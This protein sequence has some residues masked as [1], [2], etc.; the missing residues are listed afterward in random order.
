[1]R[2]PAPR[3]RRAVAATLAAGLLVA[4]AA[5]WQTA[6]RPPAFAASGAPP[7]QESTPSATEEPAAVPT[8]K[9]IEKLI[10]DDQARAAL[11]KV[12]VVLAAARERGDAAEWTRALI[13]AAQLEVALGEF[14]TAVERLRGTPWPE[15]AIHR[16]PLQL[17]YGHSLA[18]YLQAYRW[19]IAQRERVAS[20]EGEPAGDL[21]AWTVEQI[22]AGAHGAF[23]AAWQGREAWGGEPVSSLERY[24]APGNYPKGIRGTLR[25]AV[26]YLWAEL[27]VDSSFWSP[28]QNDA[29][30]RLDLE[31]LIAGEGLG[32]EALAD[33]A[34]HP[35]AKLAAV[36]GDLERWHAGAGR[37]EASF[38]AL[39]VRL[40]RLHGH[41]GEAEDRA[42]IRAALERGLDSLGRERPW[43]SMGMATLASMVD[44]SAE[45]DARARALEIAREG[46]AA[47][48]ESP[49]GQLCRHLAA[50]I[51]APSCSV[52]SMAADGAGRRSIQVTHK[53]LP[54]LWFRA[55]RLDLQR[56]IEGSA[57]GGRMLPD[58]R[59]V[60]GILRGTPAA[61]W[62]VDLPATPDHRPHQ[63]YVTPPFERPGLWVVVASAAEG[64]RRDGNHLQ[65]VNLVITD[66]VLVSRPLADGIETTVRAGAG[67]EALAG[68]EVALYRFD[69][70]KSHS[71]V[72]A[73]TTSAAGVVT[74]R[75]PDPGGEE[76]PVYFP[77]AR[78]GEDVAAD[79]S[80]LRPEGP[81]PEAAPVET[82]LIYTDRSVYRPGQEL[83]W[84][85]VAFGG[86]WEAGRYEVL[87]GR[88]LTVEL[89][90]VNDQLVAS[91]EVSTNDYG[92]ASGRF[93]VPAGRPLGG[94]R[95]LTSLD[96]SAYVQVEEYKRPTFE[97]TVAEPPE[98]LRLNREA[99]LAGEARYY[100][101]LPVAEGRVRWTVHR[102]PVFPWWWWWW[103]RPGG[104][105]RMVAAGEAELGA[106]GGFEVAFTPEADE[107]DAGTGVSYRFRLEAAVTDPGG[108]TR[109]A[110]RA[111]RLGFVAVEA[112]IEAERGFWDAGQA[113]ELP[114]VRT[115]LD[116]TP[117]AGAASWTLLAI[118]VPDE[119]PLPADLP[120][121]ELPRTAAPDA[122]EDAFRTPGDSLRPRWQPDYQPERALA[123]WPDGER[124]AAG[125]A[126]HGE[127]GRAVLELPALAA[128]AYRLRYRTE[129]GAGSTFETQHELIVAAEGSTPLPL[130]LVLLAERPS[131]EAGGTA[132]LFVHS[133][134]PGQEM[135]LELFRGGR[136]VERRTIEG[137]Q[138]GHLVEIPV[139]DDD[140]GGFGV[141]LTALAD[142][143]LMSLGTDVMVPWSDRELAI[144]FASFRDLLRPGQEETWRVTVRGEEG[145]LEAGAAELLAYMYDRSLEIFAPHQ[146]PRPLDWWYPRLTGSQVPQA[147]LGLAYPSWQDGEDWAEVPGAP[148]LE[149]A[150]L[151]VFEGYGIGGP[152]YR[153]FAASRRLDSTAEM[154]PGMAVEEGVV[155]GAMGGAEAR[156]EPSA[157]GYLADQSAA[158][159]AP[160]PA[161]PP[162][163]QPSPGEPIELRSDFAETAFWHP[164]LV[165]GEGGEV[166]FEFTVPEA[167]TEWSVWVHALTRDLRAGSVEKRTRTAKELLVRPYLPRFLREGDRA[168]LR[169]AVNNSGEETLNGTVEVRAVDPETGEDRSAEL[170]IDAGGVAR[171]FTVE[172][173][174]GATVEV[175]LTAPRHV[176]AYAIEVTARAG[177]LSDG[178]RRP[179]PVLPGRVHLA[180]S[181]FAALRDAE[182]R[183]L[184]FDD[185]AAQAGPGAD[186]TLVTDRLVVT[187]DGQ[188]FYG[189]LAALPYLVEYPYECTEQTLNRFVSTA[190]VSSVFERHPAVGAMAK[191]LAARE[192]RFEAWD[193]P[194]PN[195]DLLLE[196]TP[197]LRQAQGGAEMPEG[198]IK[199]LDPRIAR[200]QRDAALA[201]LGEAQTASGGFPWWPGGQPSPYMT[202]YTLDGLSRALERGAQVPA[203]L[204]APAWRYL[205]AWWTE[206]VHRDLVSGEDCC[207]ELVTYLGYVL[208]AY[209]ESGEW[210]GGVFSARD[211]E[212]MLAY[213]WE[214]WRSHSPR[215]KIYLALTLA[216]AG[217]R[218]DAMTVFA[219]VMDSA[220]TDR[221]LGTYWA[222]EERSWLWYNDTVESHALALAALS[223][224]APDDPRRDGLVQ[225][226]FLNKKLNHWKSTRATAEA[227]W[228]LVESLEQDGALGAAEAARVV[229][230]PVERT[231]RFDPAEYTGK[232]NQ[233]VI[234]GRE[235]DPATMSEV[236]V[237]KDTPGLL[238]ASATWH[239]STEELPEDAAEG[240][241]FTVR[242]RYFRR[243]E[244]G[245]EH[246]LRLLV[247]GERIAVG[248]QIEVQLSIT[249][250]HAAE[251]VHLR[252][253]RGAG[254]E[255]ET[256]TSGYRWD[257]GL[258]R[259][260]EI[261]DS[262]TNF[263]IE[264]LP[265]GEYTLKHRLRAATAGTFRT[266]PATL[267]SM[268][269]P[270]FTA[271]SSGQVIEVA[272][273]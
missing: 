116:G 149:G 167:V 214:H 270:E 55:Y 179:L 175:T 133:G 138:G 172:P 155:G 75:E 219:S 222:P 77:L 268:Y 191:E 65:S 194:D 57:E 200:A 67:G 61:A 1:M 97:V 33:P 12:E 107:R 203:E 83:L 252:D 81:Q 262:A 14:E 266:A 94:W 31:T 72:A 267:Q 68:V 185:L 188:L 10:E 159:A 136:P 217:R 233:L 242:R 56:W 123:L 199:V 44:Q 34:V 150:R 239:F 181:R 90:D 251:Y 13:R 160:P 180:Q 142:Y 183:T 238:F 92:S 4:S 18:A 39:R 246:V 173:D 253:P 210:T 98:P 37:S 163:P 227:I 187:L 196:E 231:F 177:G 224:L 218:A 38:E 63:T 16:L 137:G 89:R 131:V 139:G 178:E 74:F 228:A 232:G 52:V 157:V 19:E 27:L 225:W 108:E 8:W 91:E 129:D 153:A 250:R 220:R 115:D 216:R 80:H 147:S 47:H 152:G 211:R 236:A 269:A 234:P 79:L 195:R 125:T 223:E 226:L 151:K 66:L 176:G 120:L 51:V 202:L 86:A 263:F 53:D 26:S 130:P 144:E 30:Y 256:L 190:I 255:P 261:R 46:A 128:G 166:S 164:H 54:R 82:A 249:A 17:A 78:R 69:W 145:A 25:D 192:T 48:P 58:H 134:L 15:E 259:Y 5:A 101:G 189:V 110:E 32:D 143:Q 21:R 241:L 165:L 60:P 170:G 148:V 258:P 3:L 84:K 73:A 272:A 106:D 197:W 23:L 42:A 243:L 49:G 62:L 215:L 124:I 122:Q 244:Q 206:E 245:G 209:P 40:E 85:V 260:E 112:R 140:R 118:D 212:R 76:W 186:P 141:R 158:K 168:E 213:S 254:F 9:E 2:L 105:R 64:F 208:S 7:Q 28:A 247:E 182:T 229:V 121:P 117:R 126:E 273:E 193:A 161:P 235:V 36:L 169:V 248:D 257:L 95:V 205:H 59:D 96:S 264:W 230:G 271:Y 71:R 104:D 29:T 127:D 11:G 156:G 174:G 184:A 201:A 162:P 70:R 265:A 111:F 45:P 237:S 240:G 204:T 207:V 93:T 41:F 100:F 198:L 24:L 113:I 20:A 135:V 146:P 114:A 103:D 109:T 6:A 87:P 221:D 132:R 119:T 22:A 35:L 50:A 99:R 43:W 154:A 171:P 102:E 88:A